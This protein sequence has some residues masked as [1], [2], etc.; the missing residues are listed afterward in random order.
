MSAPEWVT[1][2]ALAEAGLRIERSGL[3]DPAYVVL[4][5]DGK[6]LAVAT[7]WDEAVQGALYIL[8]N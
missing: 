4:N 8:K 1:A 2:E 6:G 3:T 7:S 5:R